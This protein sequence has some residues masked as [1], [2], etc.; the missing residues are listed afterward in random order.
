MSLTN[1]VAQFDADSDLVNAWVHGGPTTSITTDSGSVRSPAKLIADLNASI[2]LD[3]EGILAQSTAQAEAAEDSA[4]AAAASEAG[5]AASAASVGALALS[6]GSGKV[7]HI[8]SGAGAVAT[9]VG[10]ALERR[11]NVARFMSAAQIADVKSGAA[12]LDVTSALQK[13]ADGGGHIDLLDGTYLVSSPVVISVAG[14]TFGGGGVWATKFKASPSFA[15][16]AMV[17]MGNKSVSTVTLAAS[18]DGL[19]LDCN[20]VAGLGGIEFYGLRDGS[21]LRNVYVYHC[22]ATA[23]YSNIAGNGT[24]LATGVMSQGVLLENVFSVTFD[25]LSNI[26]IFSLNGLFETTVINCK[27]LGGGRDLDDGVVGFGVGRVSQSRGVRLINCSA[28][29]MGNSSSLTNIGIRY[30][31]YANNCSDQFTTLE[32]IYGVGVHFG[33]VT[34]NC[35]LCNSLDPRVFSVATADLLDPVYRFERAGACNAG[36]VVA[37]NNGKVWFHFLAPGFNNYGTIQAGLDSTTIQAG[38]SIVNFDAASSPSNAVYGLTSA[39]G[40]SKQ[41]VFYSKSGQG[42]EFFDN[43][44]SFEFL[45]TGSAFRMGEP[46]RFAIKDSTGGALIDVYRDA[47]VKKIGFFGSAPV[48]K[49][50]VTGAKGGNAAITSLL[51]QLAAYGLIVDSTT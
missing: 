15:G 47:G 29:N 22:K 16:S 27:A 13:A 4:I 17:I 20:S 37:Y 49:P 30:G 21:Y 8:G 31:D 6:T 41:R 12:L 9:T 48:A 25:V 38:G 35:T 3:A 34:T 11:V 23:V 28:G 2:N 18:L 1:K 51:S 24:G 40:G 33:G 26:E 19:L 42:Y 50:T 14:T 45:T 44:S 7:G 43:K 36:P 39:S 5:A 32:N 10:E 46:D